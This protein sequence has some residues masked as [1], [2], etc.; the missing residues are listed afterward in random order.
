MST[1]RLNCKPV[2]LYLLVTMLFTSLVGRDVQSQSLPSLTHRAASWTQCDS[3]GTTVSCAPSSEPVNALVDSSIDRRVYADA[4]QLSG[5]PSGTDPIP[6]ILQGAFA[7]SRSPSR[8]ASQ[9]STQSR[10]STV[11]DENVSAATEPLGDEPNPVNRSPGEPFAMPLLAPALPFASI[12][13][14][15]ANMLSLQQRMLSRAH[16][17]QQEKELRQAR[18]LQS[19]RHRQCAQLHMSDLECQLAATNP[20]W[21]LIRASSRPSTRSQ[22]PPRHNSLDH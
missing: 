16:M 13:E 2:F 4:M 1:F 10:T 9:Q 12:T 22:H 21:P 5:G 20:D 14:S 8:P 19:H 15:D 17:R 3:T 11:L 7:T 6:A 18:E